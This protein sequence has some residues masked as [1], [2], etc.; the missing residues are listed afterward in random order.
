MSLDLS[1][2]LKENSRLGAE[3]AHAGA[4]WKM[5]QTRLT[6]SMG[7]EP[8]KMHSGHLAL[9]STHYLVMDSVTQNLGFVKFGNAV[10]GL[11]QNF[12]A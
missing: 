4:H 5:T 8:K 1:D 12:T 10:F 6:T 7:S 2:D 3:T 11:K 9:A